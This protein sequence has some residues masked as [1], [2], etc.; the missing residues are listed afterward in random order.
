MAESKP[1]G[2]SVF[3]NG[4]TGETIVTPYSKAEINELKQLLKL[5]D[6]EMT[7]LGLIQETENI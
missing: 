2:G 4:D 5:S 1:I 3:V 7:K 6:A